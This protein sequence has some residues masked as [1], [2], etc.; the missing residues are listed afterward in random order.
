MS[1]VRRSRRIREKSSR[2]DD[3]E[4]GPLEADHSTAVVQADEQTYVEGDEASEEESSGEEDGHSDEDYEEA[5]AKKRRPRSGGGSRPGS[6]G[7]KRARTGTGGTRSRMAGVG[8]GTKKEQDEYLALQE[9]FEP[10]RLFRIFSTAEDVSVEDIASD[11]LEEYNA[12]RTGA[13]KEFINFLLN[14]C[15]S[16]VQVA[17]HDVLNND[18]SNETVGEVQML[19]QDQ[20]IHEFHLYISKTQKKRSKYKPLYDNFAEFMT[21]LIEL[22]SDKDMIYIEKTDEGDGEPQTV[23][24]T[25]PLM[26]DLFTWLSSFS[27]CKIR[28][29]RYV[30]TLAMYLFQDQLTHLVVEMDTQ[31]LLKLRKQLAMEQKKKRPSVKAVHKLESTIADIQGTRTVL[32]SNIENI[33]K[34]CFVHRFK[35]VD[36]TIRSESVLH[37]AKWLENYP[38]H[39]FK[40]TYLKYFGWL[41]S[42]TSSVVRLQVLK[43]LSDLVKFINKQFRNMTDDSSLRQF[44]ER[45]KHRVLELALKDIDLQV[46]LAAVQVLVEINKFRY[47]EDSEILSITSLIFSEHEVK[48]S[49]SAKNAKFLSA[50]SKFFSHVER[51]QV[52]E[53]MEGKDPNKKIGDV[54]LGTVAEVGILMRFLIKSLSLYLN[55]QD[56]LEQTTERKVH[57]LFQAAEF[58]QPYFGHLIKPICQL[59]TFQGEFGDIS[60]LQSTEEDSDA[61]EQGEYSMEL[62]KLLLPENENTVIQYITVLSGLCHGAVAIKQHNSKAETAETAMG[63]LLELFG[64]LN[65]DSPVIFDQ[66]LKIFQLFRYED[67]I[68]YGREGAFQQL[69]EIVVKKFKDMAIYTDPDDIRRQAFTDIL[70]YTQTLSSKKIEELW[71]N[72]LAEIKIALNKYLHEMDLSDPN[73][74]DQQL[75]TLQLMYLNKLVLFGKYYRVDFDTELLEM[76]FTKYMNPLALLSSELSDTTLGIVDFKILTQVTTWNLQTWYQIFEDTNTP[77]PIS[78]PMLEL[79]KFIIDQLSI[80]LITLQREHSG[81]LSRKLAIE[82]PVCVTLL[83]TV[84]AIKLFALNLPDKEAEWRHAL[85]RDYPI[86]IDCPEAIMEVLLYLEALYAN[87]I[88]VNLERGDEEAV[89]FNDL[90]PREDKADPIKLEKELC[91]FALKL[92]SLFKLGLLNHPHIEERLGLNREALG[93]LFQSIVDDSI[94]S[95]PEEQRVRKSSPP[96]S[97][98]TAPRTDRPHT[99]EELEPIEEFSLEETT[100]R[101]LPLQEDPIEEEDEDL[102]EDDNQ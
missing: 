86:Y 91:V 17:E 43:T 87:S 60:E 16:L 65:L 98:S 21:K 36:E 2:E 33:I 70:Q 8:A 71:K 23:I 40:A 19:F 85:T 99:Q 90:A 79:N 76:L 35:D 5:R 84:T 77:T 27:V 26:L 82:H 9:D 92:R 22:A 88:G 93:S 6:G 38:E 101:P 75:Q 53:F 42:D 20:K 25:G 28:C 73:K 39:F 81:E 3:H 64:H 18:S 15:G 66:L 56:P 67:W 74:A 80:T 54:K 63:Y 102:G 96:A 72:Q 94:F 52:P 32:E 89:D 30:A 83:D 55:E 100:R 58:L 78:K 95:E 51:A 31:S 61:E 11:W 50:V 68:T 41:L 49:S 47:L 44:F 14:C 45:F 29:L 24:E 97:S 4:E 7:A 1:E 69:F 10:C 12:S 48:V 46:R 59:L 62:N 57:L 13:L 34:L 37:L